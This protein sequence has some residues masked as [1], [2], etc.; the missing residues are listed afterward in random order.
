MQ[1]LRNRKQDSKILGVV[2]TDAELKTAKRLVRLSV[3]RN[4]IYSYLYFFIYIYIFIYVY[5][6]FIYLYTVGRG[7][8]TTPSRGK[9][10]LRKWKNKNYK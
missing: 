5:F 4:H 1:K 9:D 8:V 2:Q 3:S 7:K 10:S 6:V